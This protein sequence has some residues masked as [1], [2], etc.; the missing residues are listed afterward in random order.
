MRHQFQNFVAH[1]FTAEPA[2]WE[3]SVA[4]QYDRGAGLI[5][6]ADLINPGVLDQ[7]TWRNGAII[8]VKY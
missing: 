8:L 1:L 2:E 6:M 5:V 3:N 4:R 7:F